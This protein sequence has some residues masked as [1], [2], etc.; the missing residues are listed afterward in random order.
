MAELS[1][2]RREGTA[3]AAEGQKLEEFMYLGKYA[4]VPTKT[5]SFFS[6]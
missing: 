5:V 3:L 2:A 1:L 6:K 4:T